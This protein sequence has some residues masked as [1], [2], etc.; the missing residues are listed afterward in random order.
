MEQNEKNSQKA[1]EL[2]KEELEQVNGGLKL[3]VLQ[4]PKGTC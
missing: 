4:T 1:Q 2:T 3:I